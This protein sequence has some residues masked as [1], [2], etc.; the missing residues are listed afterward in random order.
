MNQ[1]EKLKNIKAVIFDAHGVFFGE[2]IYF[3]PEH[4]EMLRKRSHVDGQGI[5]LIRDA[6]IKVG[7]ENGADPFVQSFLEK[8]NTKLPSAASGKWDKIAPINNVD[9]AEAW[10]KENNLTWEDCAYIGDDLSGYKIMQ[11]AGFKAAPAQAE[12]VVKKIADWITPRRGGDG[13][14][15]DLCNAILEAKGIDPT[16]LNLS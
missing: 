16:T 5:S 14:I 1:H 2:Y 11:K 9:E 15:R 10:L 12:D 8:F 3:N 4:G 7:F 13:A 6:G